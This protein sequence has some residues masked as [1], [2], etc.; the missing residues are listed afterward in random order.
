MKQPE[1]IR[2]NTEESSLREEIDELKVQV[3]KL[4]LTVMNPN[5]PNVVEVRLK[6]VEE[7]LDALKS[8]LNRF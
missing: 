3:K 8:K 4:Q 7:E 2:P 5:I 1:V 6:K